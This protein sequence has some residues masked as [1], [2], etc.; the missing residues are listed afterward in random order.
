MQYKSII[1]NSI[2]N[3]K[4]DEAILIIN[5]YETMFSQEVEILNMK[6]I[7]ALLNNNF[8]EA[9]MLLKKA[10]LLD[11]DNSNT[12]FNIAYL[13]EVIGETKEAIRFYL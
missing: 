9:E 11:S 10:L 3:G 2:N 1:E 13:K 8:I 5:E 7:I 6:S 12:I 4:F